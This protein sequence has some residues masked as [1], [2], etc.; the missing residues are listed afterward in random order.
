M[1]LTTQKSDRE[2]VLRAVV[3]FTLAVGCAFA[4]SVPFVQFPTLIHEG[5][6]PVFFH[7]PVLGLALA[8]L[9]GRRRPFH[10]VLLFGTI[11]LAAVL[12]FEWHQGVYDTVLGGAITPHGYLVVGNL[13]I[14]A[15]LTGLSVGALLLVTGRRV[16]IPALPDSVIVIALFGLSFLARWGWGDHVLA[17]TGRDYLLASDDG[18]MYHAFASGI[19]AGIPPTVYQRS[20]WG[21]TLYWYFLA[22]IYRVAGVDNFPAVIAIQAALGALVPAAIYVIARTLTGSQG[23]AAVAGLVCALNKVLIFLAGVLGM[24]ALYLPLVYVGLVWL[25]SQPRRRSAYVGIGLV[26]GLANM[27]RN[28]LFGYPFVLLLA[29]FLWRR[30][31][32]LAV[33]GATLVCLGFLG[34]WAAQG[35][36]TYLTYGRFMFFTDEAAVGFA[37]DK[38]GIHEN[39]LLD[40]MGFNPFVDFSRALGVGLHYPGTVAKLLGIGFVKRVAMYLFMPGDG[41][42]DPLT[43]TTSDFI[44]NYFPAIRVSFPALIDSYALLFCVIGLV[45]LYRY[46]ALALLTFVIYITAGNAL[47][48]AK[49]PRHRAVLIPI[50]VLAVVQGVAWLLKRVQREV[51]RE[52]DPTDLGYEN[53]IFTGD[54]VQLQPEASR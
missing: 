31:D 36:L 34:A 22:A 50:F 24:E 39:A 20:H 35:C 27:A 25:I 23:I 49:S 16:A 8:A 52:A 3:V 44:H 48:V 43:I 15:L 32:R 54:S 11:H 42:Y 12:A 37:M 51:E 17:S 19:V 21:G 26:F 1:M 47:L 5:K 9:V 53:R 41:L 7:F 18:Q 28:E 14:I 2:A 38:Y 6:G 45:V 46:R 29:I 4:R 30:S 13:Y 40:E 33:R 10:A